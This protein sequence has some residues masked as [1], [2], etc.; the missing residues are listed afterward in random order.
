M[1]SALTVLWKETHSSRRLFLYISAFIAGMLFITGVVFKMQHWPGAGIILAWRYSPGYPVFLPAL[2][3]G[4]WDQQNRS[5]KAVY[6][7]GC[8]GNIYLHLRTPFQ[9]PALA[10]GNDLAYNRTGSHFLCGLSVVYSVTWKDESSEFQRL[11]IWLSDA[12]LNMVP[13]I[14]VSLNV[15][16]TSRAAIS[17]SMVSSKR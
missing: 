17:W 13:S 10:P 7:I 14:L 15:Q 2:L 9:N 12:I 6:I 11:S 4:N 1:P 5:K 8:S 16:R 3:A